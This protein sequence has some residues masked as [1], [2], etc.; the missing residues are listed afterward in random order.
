MAVLNTPV[1][2]AS[3]QDGVPT[4][5][6]ATVDYSWRDGARTWSVPLLHPLL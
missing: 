1:T 5:N 6:F 3:A 2:D 4:K